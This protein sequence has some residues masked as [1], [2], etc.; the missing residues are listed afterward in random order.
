MEAKDR[1]WP[2]ANNGTADVDGDTARDGGASF[3]SYPT[4]LPESIYGSRTHLWITIY[5]ILLL[6]LLIFNTNYILIIITYIQ[7]VTRNLIVSIV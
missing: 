4:A 3:H 1:F 5:I 6:T 7:Y 2:D